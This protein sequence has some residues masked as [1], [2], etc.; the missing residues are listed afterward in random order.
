MQMTIYVSNPVRMIAHFPIVHF[1]LAAFPSKFTSD[2]GFQH[3]MPT[4]YH[5]LIFYSKL[6]QLT[7]IDFLEKIFLFINLSSLTE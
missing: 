1:N 3:I 6:M 7:F 2:T 5:F 4:E